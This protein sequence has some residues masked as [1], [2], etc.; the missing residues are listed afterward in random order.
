MAEPI[1]DLL[2][3]LGDLGRM[4]RVEA[5]KRARAHGLTRAQWFI[6]ARVEQEP[7]LSQRALAGLLEV[8]PITVARLVDRLEAQKLVERRPDPHDRRI[9]RLHPGPGAARV[10]AP[11]GVHR[12][13]IA[14]LLTEGIG[15]D[16]LDRTRTVLAQ[17]RC[18]MVQCRRPAP[19]PQ[20]LESV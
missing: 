20:P 7:G 1:T 2:T 8:E 6:L 5:D 18:N 16:E 13:A 17:M 3:L 9:W 15:S 14:K 11:L 10:L 19:L 4:I 12:D